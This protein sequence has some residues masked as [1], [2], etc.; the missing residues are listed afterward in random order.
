MNLSDFPVITDSDNKFIVIDS[1]AY[2]NLATLLNGTLHHKD[3]LNVAIDRI[4][5][6]LDNWKDREEIAEAKYNGYWDWEVLAENNLS[7]GNYFTL[8]SDMDIHVFVNADNQNVFI[9]DI[10]SEQPQFSIIEIPMTE[11][12]DVLEQ[13][14]RMI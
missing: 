12:L 5:F 9:D 1:T 13:W 2:T 10:L 8:V 4:T 11:F 6:L 14:K 3:S 7:T